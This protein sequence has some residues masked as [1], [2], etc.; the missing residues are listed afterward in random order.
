MNLE[1]AL[2]RYMNLVLARYMSL[3]CAECSRLHPCG[4]AD[5]CGSF[6][7]H[8]SGETEG[9]GGALQVFT[10]VSGKRQWAVV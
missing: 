4:D 9:S 3:V 2:A 7:Q 8:P 1:L 10:A 6:H 5:S